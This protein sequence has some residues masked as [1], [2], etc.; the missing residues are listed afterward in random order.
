MKNLF[1]YSLAFA[2]SLATN[3]A[4]EEKLSLSFQ[5]STVSISIP[6]DFT[7]PSKDLEAESSTGQTLGRGLM[8]ADKR[9]AN[10]LTV[11]APTATTSFFSGL[12]GY[13]AG[14][15]SQEGK[16]EAIAN[17]FKNE[18]K[19]DT[20]EYNEAV[21]IY[22]AGMAEAAAMPMSYA[23]TAAGVGAAVGAAIG[24]SVDEGFVVQCRK[25][26]YTIIMK[27]QQECMAIG[28]GTR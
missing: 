2:L 20:A 24:F 15:L 14:D 27:N 9:D 21:D 23:L 4:G 28:G 8:A 5:Y 1:A 6:L 11:L 7:E 18:I 22:N 26:K 13:A 12:A 25:Q 17:A 3:A 10:P 19:I 16:E